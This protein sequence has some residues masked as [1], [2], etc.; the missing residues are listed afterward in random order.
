ML[1]ISFPQKNVDEY[2]LMKEKRTVIRNTTESGAC[3]S[4]YTV[5]HVLDIS[6]NWLELKE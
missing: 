2:I 6:G 4:G 5:L 3:I 1:V